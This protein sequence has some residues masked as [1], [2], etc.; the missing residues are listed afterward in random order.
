MQ[1][2]PQPPGGNVRPQHLKRPAPLRQRRGREAPLAVCARRRGAM[3]GPPA[4][5][6]TPS[7]GG[8]ARRP[9]QSAPRHCALGVDPAAGA[10]VPFAPPCCRCAAPQCACFGAPPSGA[11]TGPTAATPPPAAVSALRVVG[12]PCSCLRPLRLLRTAK[13]VRLSSRVQTFMFALCTIRYT[14][15]SQRNTRTPSLWSV[16]TRGESSRASAGP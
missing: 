12:R 6:H 8:L 14:G 7:S 2:V 3:A 11:S 10:R 5:E 4:W 1:V 9:G 16:V 13:I 15:W